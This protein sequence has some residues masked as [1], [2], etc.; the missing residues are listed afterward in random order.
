MFIFLLITSLLFGCPY[1]SRI[2]LSSSSEAEIDKE[3]IGKWK[4]L[5]GEGNEM[6][7]VT[8][9]LFNDH[10]L[11]IV[12]KEKDKTDCEMF[13]A[14][15][16][17]VDG[18]KFL[19]IQ[20]IKGTYKDREWMFANYSVANCTLSYRIVDDEFIKKNN[21][22]VASSKKPFEFIKENLTNKDLYGHEEKTTLQC[23]KE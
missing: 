8:I 23:I 10:E 20:E 21:K 17:T 13:R 7:T 18:E 4:Y 19:N 14:F 1:Q 15:L 11:L 16:T 22:I 3:L 12:L 5:N 6:G 2:P 9:S